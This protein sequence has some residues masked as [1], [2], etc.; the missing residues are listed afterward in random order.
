[1]FKRIFIS[2]VVISVSLL[3]GCA[4]IPMAPKEQD[5]AA[6]QFSLPPKDKAGLYMY[7]NSFMG[8]ALR[9]RLLVD[10]VVIG[11]TA[12]KTFFY[13]QIMPGKHTLSTES[14]F[15]DNTV[16]LQAEGGKN[17]FVQ[18]YIKMGA[19]VGGAGLKIVSEEEGKREVL[20]CELAQ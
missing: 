6:K 20:N 7:R 1:M 10:G 18:Q 16:T 11:E 3:S 4:S 12:N 8:Q 5:T 15:G 14:E 19:F 2:A 17:Y 9:K 13:K